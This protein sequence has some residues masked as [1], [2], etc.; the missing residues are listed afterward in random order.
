LRRVT[1]IPEHLLKRSRDRR[2]ALGLG[3]DDA[4][5]SGADAPAA[6]TP[7][8]TAAATPA[9]AAPS[10]PVGRKAAAAAAPPPP[11]KPDPPYVAAAKS[12]RKIPFWAML[13][14]SLLP[15]WLFM[16]V[17]SVT[18]SPEVASGPLG[19]GA[20]EYSTCA[21]CHGSNGEG[22][23][24][25]QF[26]EGEVLLTFP[27]IEDQVRFVYFG[28]EQYNIAGV[29]IYGNPDREG[30]AHTAGSLGAMPGQGSLAGGDLT[31]D[32]IL[33]VVCHERYTLGGADPASDEYVEEYENW[34]SDESPIYEA[35]EAGTSLA[36]LADAGVVNADGE[37]IEMIPVGDAPAEGS[38]PE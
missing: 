31:D 36:D 14:L 30:G 28:T 27:H 23:V 19:V 32:E 13:S 34:C 21:S 38:P 15:V 24:G 5:T 25:Y 29:S 35:L 3:G 6:S 18:E 16:Y 7:A 2:S 12:R 33:A 10:G 22:G 11:P 17:R 37:P 20:A 26:S 8:T 1:E 9:A 4:G